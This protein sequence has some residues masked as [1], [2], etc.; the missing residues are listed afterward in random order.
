MKFWVLKVFGREV[1]RI[2]ERFS[3]PMNVTVLRRRG[4]GDDIPEE[5]LQTLLDGM[6]PC[7]GC[8]EMFDPESG[9]TETDIRFAD[10]AE[11]LIREQIAD[12]DDEDD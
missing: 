2:E 1:L 12:S 9:D 3:I 5:V 11:Q 7:E 10:I 4:S 8:G 6:T